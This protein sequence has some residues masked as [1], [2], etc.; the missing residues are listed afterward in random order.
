M[1]PDLFPSIPTRRKSRPKP[2]KIVRIQL[3]ETSSRLLDEIGIP[4]FGVCG[5]EPDPSNRRRWILYLAELPA[6]ADAIEALKKTATS[7]P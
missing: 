4:A 7:D 3:G 1:N 5:C 6:A 2:R